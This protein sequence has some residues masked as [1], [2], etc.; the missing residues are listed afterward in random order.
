MSLSSFLYKGADQDLLKKDLTDVFGLTKTSTEVEKPYAELDAPEGMIPEGGDASGDES[1]SENEDGEKKSRKRKAE[2]DPEDIKAAKRRK[3]EKEK[4]KIKSLTP[5]E[6]EALNEEKN[7][8]TVFVSNIPITTTK[9]ELQRVFKKHG[10]IESVRFRNIA[11][12][13]PDRLKKLSLMQKDFHDELQ[14]M[15]AYVVFKEVDSVKKALA[16]NN[17]LFK[18]HH[19][20]VDRAVKEK[21]KE[22]TTNCVFIGNLPISSNE[23]TI[24]KHFE[25]EVGEIEYVRII[26]DPT[27][28]VCKGF[29][30]IKFTTEDNMNKAIE[31]S[32]KTSFGG[33]KIRIFPAVKGGTKQPKPRRN[34]GKEI[35]KYGKKK[36]K[37]NNNRK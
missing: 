11:F 36:Q 14:T 17:T 37:Q 27:Y 34:V 24:R 5:E 20:R 23:E 2:T 28:K 31:L 29:G 22:D 13:N 1:G 26:R 30:Y 25:A 15:N 32:E 12:K 33:R 9:K 8:Q 35:K 6:R 18:E 19:I 4:E 10:E 21:K 7:K 3:R 16:E